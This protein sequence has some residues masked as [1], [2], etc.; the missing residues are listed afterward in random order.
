MSHYHTIAIN[1]FHIHETKL[2]SKMRSD[3]AGARPARD[4]SCSRSI[5]REAALRAGLAIQIKV[6][7]KLK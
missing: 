5:S 2:W 4:L 7:G 3:R 1:R 6:P